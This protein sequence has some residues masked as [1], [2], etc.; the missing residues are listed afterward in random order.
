MEYKDFIHKFG[1]KIFNE[2]CRETMRRIPDNSV[3]CVVTSPPYWGLRDY[4]VEPTEWGGDKGCQH[5][6]SEKVIRKGIKDGINNFQKTPDTESQY[7]QYCGAWRGCYGLEPT[8]I[9]Y[10]A[11]TSEIFE[12]VRRILRPDGVCWLN[13]GDTYN[14]SSQ[15][16]DTGS[17]GMGNMRNPNLKPKDLCGIPWRVAFALQ[18]HGW[19]L[20][21]DVIWSKVNGIPESVGDRCT[22]SHEYLFMLTKSKKYYFDRYAI[23]QDY[24][25]SIKFSKRHNGSTI[26]GGL[27]A[28]GSNKKSVWHIPSQPFSGGHNAV[29]PSGLVVDPI[30]ASTSEYGCC[31]ACGAAW[32]RVVESKTTAWKKSCSC[33]NAGS[34]VPAI[35]YDPFSG[36][37]TVAEILTR[38][39]RKYLGSEISAEYCKMIEKRLNHHQ[40]FFS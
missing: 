22:K 1:N 26:L 34:P 25:E 38:L 17:L 23:L 13:I 6:F 14:S 24:A 19:W 29:M 12:H 3:H 18:D 2:D 33:S 5:E 16:S 39:G 21:Q 4:G 30:K 31:A 37:G 32:E 20:R 8:I 15:E 7:C 10:V 11:N 36:S 27:K 9:Q 40:T 35:G 28:G